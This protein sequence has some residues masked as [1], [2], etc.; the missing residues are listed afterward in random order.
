MTASAAQRMRRLR[1]R[2]SRGVQMVQIEIDGDLL[3]ALGELGL[4]DPDEAA[5]SEALAF[6]LAMLLEE[7]A[8]AR[9][10]RLKE[11]SL[12]VTSHPRTAVESS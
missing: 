12:R 9:R 1:E 2:R 10:G 3:A 11:N 6:A 7:A 5:D 4:I 8:E